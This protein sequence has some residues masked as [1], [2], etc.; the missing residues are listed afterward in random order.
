GIETPWEAGIAIAAA[1]D[2]EQVAT[3]CGAVSAADTAHWN[4]AMAV[5]AN[6]AVTA[7]DIVSAAPVCAHAAIT[8]FIDS[9]AAAILRGIR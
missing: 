2:T 5:T 4:T 6:E 8:L 7:L 1:I 9:R 3:A